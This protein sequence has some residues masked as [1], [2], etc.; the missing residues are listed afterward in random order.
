M[1]GGD[2][3][4]TLCPPSDILFVEEK[5]YL[6]GQFV[7]DKIT[8]EWKVK[9][10]NYSDTVR[11]I[12][13]D[14]TRKDQVEQQ[15]R[16]PLLQYTNPITVR[17]KPNEMIYI[18]SLWLHHITQEVSFSSISCPMEDLT[19]VA[20]VAVNYWYEMNF[21]SPLYVYF[22]LLQQMKFSGTPNSLNESLKE[23]ETIVKQDTADTKKD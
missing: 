16:Y 22:H 3:I 12:G 21:S 4:I 15:L 9:L 20:T 1:S 5:E 7:Q 23:T 18:P 10:L 8:K 19:A 11:W 17:V 14:V 13:G 6:S 2:K